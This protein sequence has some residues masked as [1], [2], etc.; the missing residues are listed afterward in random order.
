[1]VK[2]VNFFRSSIRWKLIL[3]ITI[4]IL[5]VVFSISFF[6]IQETSRTIKDDVQRYSTQILKQANLN[7]NRYFKEYEQGFLTMGVSEEFE[8]WLKVEEGNIADMI[9][10]F[11][12]LKSKYIHPLVTR[13]REIL[14]VSILNSNG[15]EMYYVGSQGLDML[16]SMKNQLNELDQLPLNKTKIDVEVTDYYRDSKGKVV[17][18]VVSLTRAFRRNSAKGYIKLDISLQPTDDIL[19]DIYLGEE[20]YVMIANVD[21]SVITSTAK[22][23]NIEKI[24]DQILKRIHG[25]SGSFFVSG[26]DDLVMYAVIPYT[27]WLTIAVVPYSDVAG[28]INHLRKVTLVVTLTSLSVGIFL[29]V[30]VSSSITGRLVKLRNSIKEVMKGNLNDVVTVK[31]M[32]EVSELSSAYNRMLKNLNDTIHDLAETRMLEQQ[33]VLSALQSQINSHFLYNTLETINSMANLANHKDIEDVTIALSNMLRYTSS[34][35]DAI[36]RIEDEIRHTKNY[37]KI[38]KIRYGDAL[39]FSLQVDED[40]READC[41][42]AIIQ[43]IIEN[44]IKHGIELTGKPIHIHVHVSTEGEYIRIRIEDNGNGFDSGKLAELQEK[45]SSET[46]DDSYSKLTHVGILN[47]QYRLRVFY[48]DRKAGIYINNGDGN[49]GAVVEMVFP[50]YID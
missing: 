12:V 40:C 30:L 49:I 31:G 28:S 1:M 45:L 4:I 16:Y 46:P 50:R 3:V 22:G 48:K 6:T 29:V 18:K 21:G 32:D 9:V 5:C 24:D 25:T 37:M 15:N 44:C 47:I 39:T 35:K 36:V 34:Y 7:L 8:A 10:N 27:Q 14:S 2:I 13:H 42:K 41:L 17:Q 38:M 43:P 19:N 33:A 26:V 23:R 20:G 11:N